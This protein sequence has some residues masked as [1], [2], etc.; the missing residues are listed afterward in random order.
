MN[1]SKKFFFQRCTASRSG[2]LDDVMIITL[3]FPRGGG[4]IQR[5]EGMDFADIA[6]MRNN[7]FSRTLESLRR[8]VKQTE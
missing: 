5:P 3:P 2:L 4:L 8:G 1:L 7:I 6:D